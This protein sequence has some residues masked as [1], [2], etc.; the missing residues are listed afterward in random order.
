MFEDLWNS[1]LEL[2]SKFVIPDWGSVIAMLP[3]LVFAGA[4]VV[5]GILFWIIWR[6][7][8]PRVGKVKVEPVPPAG[9][10][11]PGPSWAPALAALGAFMLFLGLVFGG[12]LLIVGVIGL[13]VTLL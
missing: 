5:I 12:P 3:V 4:I 6:H 7:P 2:T 1:I 9:V 13:T 11:M 10:H 8:K